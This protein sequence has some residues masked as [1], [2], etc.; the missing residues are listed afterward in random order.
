M[1]HNTVMINERNQMYRAGRFLWLDWAQSKTLDQTDNLIC[2]EHYGYKKLGIVHRRTLKRISTQKWEIVDLVFSQYFS[3]DKYKI[4]LHWLLPN[5]P[6]QSTRN[7]CTL[8]AP[9]GSV[10]LH[11]SSEIKTTSSELTIYKKGRPI[12]GNAQEESL[13]GW[14]SPTYGKKL[15]ALSIR[16]SVTHAVP[17]TITSQFTFL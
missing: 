4:D 3:K 9:F 15:P 14:F 13:L 12:S 1:A 5:W 8:S 11:I 2:A 17:F 10:R 16:Y 6:L 7:T